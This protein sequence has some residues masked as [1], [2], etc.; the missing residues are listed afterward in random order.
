LQTEIVNSAVKN[1]FIVL[2]ICLLNTVQ[3]FIQLD[4]G[5]GVATCIGP[6][7][8]QEA[9]IESHIQWAAMEGSGNVMYSDLRVV[10]GCEAKGQPNRGRIN[11]W[12]G[13]VIVVLSF[14]QIAAA[15]MYNFLFVNF[16]VGQ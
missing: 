16:P 14:L 8:I 3:I 7:V 9:H 12:R 10:L 11:D 2:P 13:D 4:K 1:L 15:D 5:F 6:F